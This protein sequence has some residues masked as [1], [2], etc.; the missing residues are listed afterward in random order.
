MT[1]KT[2]MARKPLRHFTEVLDVKHKTA[3]CR[4]GAAKSKRKSIRAGTM[5]CCSIKKRRGHN[6]INSQLKE[7]I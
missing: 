1:V 5:L 4:L 3:I 6:K 7:D 2:P